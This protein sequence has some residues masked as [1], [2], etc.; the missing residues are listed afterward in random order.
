MLEPTTN[1]FSNSII[2]P[3]AGINF[4]SLAV[5]LELACKALI[6]CELHLETLISVLW[7]KKDWG[8]RR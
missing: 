3:V 8:K 4:P 7:E 5:L 6:F 2:W 1:N